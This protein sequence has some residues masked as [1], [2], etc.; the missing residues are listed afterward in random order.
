MFEESLSKLKNCISSHNLEEINEVSNITSRGIYLI[1][2]DK[3]LYNTILPI[4]IGQTDNFQKRYKEH[5]SKLLVLNRIDYNTLKEQLNDFSDI[6]NVFEGNYGYLK[7]FKYLI[8]N[9]LTLYNFHMVILKKCDS[10]DD[11]DTLELE[12]INK[13][14][15]SYFGFNQLNSVSLIEKYKGFNN[16]VADKNNEMIINAV[17]QDLRNY[18]QYKTFG[19]NQF[20]YWLLM[21]LINNKYN[22]SDLFQKK[23]TEI[24]NYYLEILPK[25]GEDDLVKLRDANKKYNDLINNIKKKLEL[26]IEKIIPDEEKKKQNGIIIKCVL[27]RLC[28]I[29][30]YNYDYNHGKSLPNEEHSMYK[31][32]NKIINDEELKKKFQNI[33][34][35]LIDYGNN[36]NKNSSEIAK[37]SF[38]EMIPLAN[39]I[40]SC[41]ENLLKYIFPSKRFDAFSISKNYISIIEKYNIIK[42]N[43]PTLIFSFSFEKDTD[44]KIVYVGLYIP[45]KQIVKEW[46]LDDYFNQN[47]VNT[48]YN[49]H[50]LKYYIVNNFELIPINLNFFFDVILTINQEYYTGINDK[51]YKN[52]NKC[53]WRNVIMELL[54]I[55]EEEN[56]NF[57]IYVLASGNNKMS[58]VLLGYFSNV[59]NPEKIKKL[60]SN[61]NIKYLKNKLI[62]DIND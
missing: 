17:E 42:C 19:F 44:K 35:E 4:Y 41:E 45:N 57:Q 54:K 62:G 28:N 47:Y 53:D 23:I 5:I 36:L 60:F 33:M 39:Y 14:N 12:Y 1:Y 27:S 43:K 31:Y 51:I 13:F 20:N 9:N 21:R 15:S 49:N 18:D 24:K 58:E 50:K 34:E 46:I 59:E 6:R 52:V 10:N 55:I 26:E 16:S 40:G 3:L 22:F 25:K 11:L 7:I 48:I 56:Y 29:Y 8:D 30:G 61:N 32:S 38:A 2:I 37:I